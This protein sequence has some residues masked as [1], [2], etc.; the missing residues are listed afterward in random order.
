MEIDVKYIKFGNGYLV[1]QEVQSQ[2]TTT[3]KVKEKTNHIWIYDRSYSMSYE[4]PNMINQLVT[5]SENLPKGDTITLGYFSS[6]GEYKF[7]IKGFKITNKADYAFLEAT[8]RKNSRPIGCTC[9]SEIINET[10]EV[11][12]DLSLFSKTFSF[13]FFTDGYPV[14]HNYQKEID[15]IR[16]GIDKIKGKLTTAMFI[17]CGHFYNKPLMTKMAERIGGMLIHNDSIKEFTPTITRLV[18]LSE[19]SE[20]KIE[21]KSPFEKPVAVYTV[22]DQGVVLNDIEDGKLSVSPETGKSVK[23]YYIVDDVS[24]LAAKKVTPVE[25][26]V[27]AVYGGTL[28][29][30]QQM[31][32]DK[33]ME[34]V[35]IVGDKYFIDKL[36]NAFVI[37]EYGKVENELNDAIHNEDERFKNGA[38]KNYL[39]K[40]D[41]FNVFELLNIL[42]DDDNSVFYPYDKRFKYEKISKGT[43]LEDGYSKFKPSSD[44]ECS[45]NE[46]VWHKSRLNLSVRITSK[47]TIE[48]QERDGKNAGDYGFT[49]IFPTWVYRNYSFVKDG[50]PN[51]K[52]FYVGTSKETYET[53]KSH[54]IVVD[55]TFK[56]NGIYGLDISNLPS[57]NRGMANGNTNGTELCRN[58]YSELDLMAQLKVY[59]WFLK[60]EFPDDDK[61]PTSFSEEQK[62]FLEANGILVDKGGVYAP[63]VKSGIESFDYYMVKRFEIKVKSLTSLPSLNA[64]YKKLNSGKKLTLSESLLN[65]SIEKYDS[66]KDDND[67]LL[68]RKKYLEDT[69]TQ[70]KIKLK[71]IRNDIQKC[72]FAII[73]GR[74]WFQEFSSREQTQLEVD[75]NTFNFLL[76]DEKVKI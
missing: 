25:L 9:F 73:L 45:F 53:L 64:V 6:E 76:S 38:D 18:Q 65:E 13:A 71:P 68:E 36:T 33:A 5:L 47:G 69:I 2:A 62:G 39:P 12:E 3:K 51:I 55:D 22:T 23:L 20:P 46:L 17:G 74:Q 8:I 44:N 49:Q 29:L 27:E 1:Q 14:V 4:L 15:N 32:T 59:K 31:K 16:I 66:Y 10:D 54:G 60:E 42:K 35:G 50:R 40:S 7:I 19:S 37:D 63:P 30:C 21:V 43:V 57:M 72:K 61:D 26:G 24:G 52:K 56:K 48:L 28:V 34:L 67:S 11:I 70:L 41:A 75:G 58:V